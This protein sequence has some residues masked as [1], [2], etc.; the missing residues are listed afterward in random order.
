MARRATGR[1]RPRSVVARRL[2]RR[3]RLRRPQWDPEEHEVDRWCRLVADAGWIVDRASFTFR[4]LTSSHRHRVR[5]WSI[6]ARRMRHAGG[7]GAVRRRGARSA[8]A[9]SGGLTGSAAEAMLA[10][11]IR[12]LSGRPEVGPGR[13]DGPAASGGARRVGPA[14]GLRRHGRGAPGHGLRRPSVLLFGPTP[15]AR[16]GTPHGGPHTVLWHG[17]RPGDP[18]GTVPAR[19]SCGSPSTRASVRR[20]S[21][22]HP[23]FG[24]EPVDGTGQ[25]VRSG[26]ERLPAKADAPG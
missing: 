13:T 3:G 23:D 10:H 15:P 8:T 25:A 24:A 17:E 19:P 20:S 14:G 16:W 26:D 9:E 11:R 1:W 4:S 21:G 12:R 7:A 5:S 2:C 6:P 22:W 18:L